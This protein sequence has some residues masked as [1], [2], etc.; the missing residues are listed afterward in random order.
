MRK[1]FLSFL[2]MGSKKE[3]GLFRYDKAFYELDERESGKTEFVQVAQIQ[4]LGPS[5]FDMI[6]I[7]ATQKSYDEHFKELENQLLKTGANEVSYIIIS[8]DMTPEGQWEWFERILNHIEYGDELTIDLTHGYRSI[9]IVFSTAINF[10][11]KSRGIILNAVYYGAY[12]KNRKLSPIINMKDFYIINEWADAVSR[13]VEDADARKLAEVAENTTDFQ[14]SELND[15][16]LVESF[17]ELTEVVKNV[18]VNNIGAKANKAISLVKEKE[19][20][21]SITGRLLL[22]LVYDKFISIATLEPATGRYDSAYFFLQ[23]EIIDLLLKHKLFMQAYTVM[24]EFIGSIGMIEIEKA[25][26]NSNKGRK[27]RRIFAEIFIQMFQR[28]E[29]NWNFEGKEEKL[30]SLRPYYNNLKSVGVEKILRDFTD[31]LADYRNGFD[32]AWTAKKQSYSDI[33][34]KGHTFFDNLK[35]VVHLLR[36][37]NILV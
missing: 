34:K 37:N 2:G 26:I 7:V 36:E 14:V 6:L 3:N 8:E 15:K 29:N 10:L 22:R 11:Q 4:I 13:L 12:D 25:R 19:R 18:D 21:A 30:E 31:E 28:E 17:E 16:E 27:Q 23:L 20:G 1:V 35:N 24:R 9:P 32:H 5:N 33:E